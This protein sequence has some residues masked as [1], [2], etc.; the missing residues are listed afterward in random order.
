MID[1][2]RQA[3]LDEAE[4]LLAELELGLLELEQS[5]ADMELVGRVF[6][7]MHTIKGSSAMFGYDAIAAL[8][9]EVEAVL[10][11]VRSNRLAVTTPLVGTILLARDQ[12]KAML[13]GTAGGCDGITDGG[14]VIVASLRELVSSSASPAVAERASLPGSS[15]VYGECGEITCLIRFRPHPDLFLRGINPLQILNELRGLGPCRV[16]AHTDEVPLLE[17]LDP[18]LCYLRWDVELVTARGLDAVQDAFIFVDQE[19]E[20]EIEVLADANDISPDEEVGSSPGAIEQHNGEK[21][22]S[23]IR[24]EAAKLDHLVNLVGEL[25]TVQARISQTAAVRNDTELLALAEDLE[26]LTGG[27]RDNALNIRMLPIGGTFNRFR[28]IVHDLGMELGKE[29]VL[30]TWGAETELDKTVIERLTDP[31]VHIV[32]NSIDHGIETPQLR[33]AAGKPRQGAIHLSAQH[34]GGS[35]I[36]AIRDDGAGMDREALRARGVE[37]GLIPAGAEL[38]DRDLMNLIFAPGFTTSE[39]VTNVSG[40]GVGMDVVKRAMDSLRGS[41]SVT[42]LPGDGTTITLTIPL[43]LAIIESLLVR[44]GPDCFVLPLSLVEEC[45]ELTS[46]DRAKAHGRHLVR[47]RDSIVP[48]IPL[49]E[50][51]GARGEAPEIEQVVITEVDGKRVGLVVDHVIG[52]HQTVIKSIGRMFRNV[53][54]V[55]GATILGNG[56][57]ALI[58]D[59]QQLVQDEVLAA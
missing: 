34:S 44:V 5:P 39:L 1:R 10:E 40:R 30:E 16:V 59:V 47:V 31:L 33:L 41:V 25:V 8:G 54:G 52:E 55:S 15:P 22:I 11:L 26:R 42:S 20:V 7:A 38:P 19:R 45:V 37:R 32:R 56:T 53:A 4:E 50:R 13:A 24:V 49:R 23:S 12:I 21:S 27:L 29:V 43:T 57:V 58:L 3:F 48:Y 6:R 14:R 36:I 51:F 28:R 2:Y 9:H 17:E 46:A 18:E 35:V